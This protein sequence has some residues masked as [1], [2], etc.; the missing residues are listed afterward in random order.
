MKLNYYWIKTKGSQWASEI[1]ANE[2]KTE[3]WNDF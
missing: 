1:K 3:E 2:Y